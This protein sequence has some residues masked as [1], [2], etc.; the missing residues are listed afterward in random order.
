M[1]HAYILLE[2]RDENSMKEDL[3]SARQSLLQVRADMSQP[4][5]LDSSLLLRVNWGLMIAGKELSCCTDLGGQEKIMHIKEAERYSVEVA[6]AVSR[7]SNVGA[8]VQVTLEQYIFRGMRALLEFQE[9]A[10]MDNVG[11]LKKDAVKGIN[12]ALKE[13]KKIDPV[14]F[15]ENAELASYWREH[16]I[17]ASF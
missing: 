8:R 16:F 15:N 14:K 17:K 9:G 2:R 13:L 4:A 11:G 3:E 6:D 1:D 7:S 5:I 12:G 10:N